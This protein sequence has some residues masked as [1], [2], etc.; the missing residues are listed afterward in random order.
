MP[1]RR[2]DQQLAVDV[3]MAYAAMAQLSE[4]LRL[5]VVAVDVL[6]LSHKEA[7]RSL[8]TPTRT[9]MSRL[10]RAREE[11]ASALGTR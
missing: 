2:A 1:D 11:L 10:F 8:R 9:I 4:P 7:A 5:T 6:G 3:R